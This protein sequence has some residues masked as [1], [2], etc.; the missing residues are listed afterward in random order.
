[1]SIFRSNNNPNALVAIF[2]LLML[3]IFAGP[4]TLPRLVSSVIPGA[5]ESVPCNWLRLGTGRAIHQSLVG[6]AAQQPIEIDVK[7]TAVP[8]TLEGSVFVSIII[9]NRSLGTVPILVNADPNQVRFGDD[10]V[11]SGLGLVFNNNAQLPAGPQQQSGVPY[12]E[13]GIRLLGPRQSCVNKVELPL[14]NLPDPAILNGQASVKAYYRNTDPG[15]SQPVT[16]GGT[17]IFPTQG[18]WV[19]IAQS[20]SIPIPLSSG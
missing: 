18:L 17:V 3:A 1:M 12:P 13:S 8:N 5:D 19:G 10:G 6:R 2:L 14:N 11:T 7:T 9:T 4:D 15:T 20:E 16:P